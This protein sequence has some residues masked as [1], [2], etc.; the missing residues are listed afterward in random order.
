MWL[1]LVEYL[2]GVQVVAGSN[3]VIPTNFSSPLNSHSWLQ[4][5]NYWYYAVFPRV[6]RIQL[7]P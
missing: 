4:T 2:N 6:Y 1:S 3:P 5:P 7:A